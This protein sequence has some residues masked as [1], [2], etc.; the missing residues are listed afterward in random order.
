MF[1]R[2]K[3][4]DEEGDVEQSTPSFNFGVPCPGSKPGTDQP[5]KEGVTGQEDLLSAVEAL[6]MTKDA[7]VIIKQET[8]ETA[9]G[10][11]DEIMAGFNQAVQEEAARGYRSVVLATAGQFN[12]PAEELEPAAAQAWAQVDK[13]LTARGLK[14]EIVKHDGTEREFGNY[15]LITRW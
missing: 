6:K 15:E 7:L 14:I 2:H 13:K 11:F 5:D 8:T 12:G 9:I 4:D 10:Y 3:K 1:W